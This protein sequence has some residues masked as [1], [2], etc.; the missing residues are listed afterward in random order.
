ML[1]YDFGDSKPN[2]CHRSSARKPYSSTD[3]GYNI[4][5][6]KVCQVMEKGYE[7]AHSGKEVLEI[8]GNT[9]PSTFK[10]LRKISPL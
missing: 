8:W 3:P 2:A 4:R 10:L 6:S 7:E 1:G 5:K 9:S